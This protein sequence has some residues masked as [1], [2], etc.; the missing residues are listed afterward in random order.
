MESMQDSRQKEEFVLFTFL[1]ARLALFSH[2]INFKRWKKVA[3]ERRTVLQELACG[4][5]LTDLYKTLLL[6][7]PNR[8]LSN[9]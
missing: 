3:D 6:S 4:R 5:K 9:Q 8:K 2:L 7:Y 1:L